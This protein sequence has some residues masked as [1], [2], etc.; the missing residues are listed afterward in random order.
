MVLSQMQDGLGLGVTGSR[1]VLT[2]STDQA[3]EV[4]TTSP[5]S[6]GN[7]WGNA[8]HHQNSVTTTGTQGVLWIENDVIA[9]AAGQNALYCK[10]NMNA[11]Q[12]PTGGVS[13][14]NAEMVMPTG[15]QNGG[16]YHAIV[17]DIDCPGG[18]DL[19]YN[20][21]IPLSFMKLEVYGLT[22]DEW[23]E[24]ANLFYLSGITDTNDGMFEVETVAAGQVDLTH[25]LRI[26]IGGADY[27]I[28]L[29]SEKTF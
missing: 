4:F 8:L 14:I 5:T 13:V 15:V 2:A 11:I 17:V 21:A 19:V 23:N 7:H 29:N 1:M 16:E 9:Q 27:W 24:C 28:G 26:N 3:I 6:S 18:T 12:A 25:V 10:I 22:D 20:Q